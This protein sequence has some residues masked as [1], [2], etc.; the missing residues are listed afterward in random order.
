MSIT[1]S[2]G[3]AAQV[4]GVTEPQLNLLVRKRRLSSIPLV[5]AGRRMWQEEHVRE[6]AKLL[7]VLTPKIDRAITAAFAT[8]E[9]ARG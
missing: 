9:V 1:V 6:A 5:A 2:T 3:Q 8:E 4:I 7:D